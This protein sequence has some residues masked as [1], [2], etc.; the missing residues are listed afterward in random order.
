MQNKENIQKGISYKEGYKYVWDK[1]TNFIFYQNN[2]GNLIF[3]LSPHAGKVNEREI[4]KLFE[5][6]L[7]NFNIKLVGSG[8]FANF[9]NVI[10]LKNFYSL[11]TNSTEKEII[12]NA[13]INLFP[14]H[15]TDRVEN[16]K[17][18]KAEEIKFTR[19]LNIN[20]PYTGFSNVNPIFWKFDKEDYTSIRSMVNNIMQEI[21]TTFYHIGI[22]RN[23]SNSEHKNEID[24]NN[25]ELKK[26][27]NLSFAQNN[28]DVVENKEGNSL[29]IYDI[30]QEEN[31]KYDECIRKLNKFIEFLIDG[32][33]INIDKINASEYA[34]LYREITGETYPFREKIGIKVEEEILRQKQLKKSK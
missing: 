21:L 18:E 29:N 28:F 17:N 24:F 10:Y 19:T 8:F 30:A 1:S 12:K 7:K 2:R 14:Y 3:G 34:I 31:K 33:V 26:I 6:S 4:I 13:I 27:I 16:I 15:D 22:I 11:A 25:E 20:A 23:C 5:I 9:L 32:S